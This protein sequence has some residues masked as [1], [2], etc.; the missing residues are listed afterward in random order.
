AQWTHRA[1]RRSG[2]R[3]RLLSLR[4]GVPRPSSNERAE[5]SQ[6]RSP[7][8][9]PGARAQRSR[10]GD[11][12]KPLR[13]GSVRP[14]VTCPRLPI[15]Y[16]APS[17]SASHFSRW[18]RTRHALLGAAPTPLD[19]Q[20]RLASYRWWTF[21]S[22]ETRMLVRTN[23]SLGHRHRQ[24]M[25]DSRPATLAAA[26]PH[27]AQAPPRA[28]APSE[29][30][31]K[32]DVRRAVEDRRTDAVLP[33]TETPAQRFRWRRCSSAGLLTRGAPVGA[34]SATP[35]HGPSTGDTLTGIVSRTLA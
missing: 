31:A 15:V 6:R 25:T 3:E 4:G 20:H 16:R 23:T 5:R 7:D 17:P 30:G 34:R 13:S 32:V 1:H 9:D 21:T 24:A 19:L 27:A 28:H 35:L 33:L 12:V 29:P 22:G 18:I 14:P 10:S 8:G 11:H 2:R 26:R